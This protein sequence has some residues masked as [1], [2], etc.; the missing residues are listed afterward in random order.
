MTRA[1]PQE[2]ALTF[3]CGTATLVGIVHLPAVAARRGVLIVVGGPQ[4]RIGS[5]RQFLL[6][7]RTLAAHGVAA[8]R[9]DHRGIGDSGG[10]YPG[11]E[12]LDDDIGTAVD[13]FLAAC[14]E[15]EEVVLWG[16]C[17]AASAILFYAHRDPRVA[18]VVLLNPWVRTP[19]SEAAVFLRHYYLRRLMARDFWRRLLTGQVKPHTA[20]T[21]LMQLLARRFRTTRPPDS[22]AP[23]AD[24]M[25]EGFARFGGPV[26]LITSGQ[27]LTA[28]EF[29]DTVQKSETWRRLTA[30]VRVRWEKLAPA[31]HTFSRRTWRD[32]VACWTLDWLRGW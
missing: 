26:L 31:D 12:A 15:L 27:D 1:Q 28:R 8:M 5:H 17:D 3:T 9:F 7:A 22:H 25:A 21:S 14:P 11:F 32:K 13:A 29:E 19:Q 16:L 18:G 10:T 6:L 2:R 4:Y 23:L 24:R 30:E 20:A